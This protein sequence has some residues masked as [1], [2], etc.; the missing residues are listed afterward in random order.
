VQTRLGDSRHAARLRI[1]AAVAAFGLALPVHASA[2]APPSFSDPRAL[3]G[4]ECLAGGDAAGADSILGAALAAQPHALEPRLAR[5]KVAWW[6]ILEGRD[7][8]GR[9]EQEMRV[10]F[11]TLR[12]DAELRLRR[13]PRDAVAAYTLG[14]AHFTLG[15]LDA[16]RGNTWSTLQH[17]Q[18][19]ATL[20]ETARR[21][22]PAAPEPRASLGLYRY[23]AA[24]LPR[25]LRLLGRIVQVRGDRTAGLR[26]LRA[27][28]AQPGVQQIEATFFLLEVLHHMEAE[29]CEALDLALRAH[30]RYP[31]HLGF[32]LQLAEILVDWQRPDLARA[33][34]EP[35]GAADRSVQLQ[36]DFL[37]LRVDADSGRP[38][39]ALATLAG[40]DSAALARVSWIA[41]W[42]TVYRGL[43]LARLGDPAA[44]R[45]W[46]ERGLEAPDLAGSR[47]AARAGL[48]CLEGGN[49]PVR[50]SAEST[51]VWGRDPEAAFARLAHADAAGSDPAVRAE[52]AWTRGRAA[53]ASGDFAAAAAAFVVVLRDA[54]GDD[55]RLVT[56]ARIGALQALAWAGQV[57]AARALATR[58]EPELGEWGTNRQLGLA[59]GEILDPSPPRLAFSE[60]V[61]SGTTFELADTGFLAMALVLRT[62]HGV[63]TLPMVW[64]RGRWSVAVPLPPGVYAY[65]FRAG[66]TLEFLDPA[67]PVQETPD[68]AWSVRQVASTAS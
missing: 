39:R 44:A 43:C 10:D 56:G 23:Y 3:R 26:D 27:A 25:S 18:T 31:Q 8:S 64:R 46:L 45:S 57:D 19:G 4:L 32:T 58:L 11:E 20:L 28:A 9:L 50:A 67:A 40:I 63:E 36:R 42:A 6:Q 47:G 37:A 14:E 34:L 15:R 53:L 30:A 17:H 61:A 65:R 22:C 68:S 21:A 33:L 7:A 41:P 12:R 2:G 54:G 59:I 29:N 66:A 55:A 49:E 24:R 62:A 51:L 16:L 48:A 1:A 5:I 35:E 13:A 60:P 52:L 38:G